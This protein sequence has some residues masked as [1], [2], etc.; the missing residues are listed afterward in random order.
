VGF[1]RRSAADALGLGPGDA[2]RL[3]PLDENDDTTDDTGADAVP[4]TPLPLP[5]RRR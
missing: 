1:D 2:V 5:Q 3:E 4:P